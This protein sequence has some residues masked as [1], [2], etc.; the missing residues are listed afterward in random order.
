[1]Y[2][3]FVAIRSWNGGGSQKF[4]YGAT[5]EAASADSRFP[6]FDALFGPCTSVEVCTWAEYTAGSAT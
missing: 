5:P 2:N 4:G 6:G 3:A 1:M